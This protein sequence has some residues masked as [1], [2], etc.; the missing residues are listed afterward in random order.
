MDYLHINPVKH[1]LVERVADWP[2]SSFHK[3]VTTGVYAADWAGDAGMEL[4]VG[5]AVDG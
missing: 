3:L 2:Y 1:G 5:E 4:A